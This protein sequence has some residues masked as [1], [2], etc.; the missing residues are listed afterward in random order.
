MFGP[1][2][3]V[4]GGLAGKA[5]ATI[6]GMGDYTVQ[7][8]S[9]LDTAMT[10][11]DSV[12][13]FVKN[14]HSVTIRHREYITDLAVPLTPGAFDLNSYR[15]N[16]GDEKT[17][18]WLSRIARQYQ[19]YKFKGAVFVYKTMS[20]DITAGGALGTVVIA[21]NYN[22]NDNE[23][24]SKMQMEQSEFC[25]STK[26]SQSILHP[27]ECAPGAG[28][29]EFL[30]VRTPGSESGAMQDARL[31]DWG[32]TQVATV[33]LPGTTGNVLGELWVSYDIELTKP[34][35]APELFPGT[36]EISGTSSWTTATQNTNPGFNQSLIFISPGGLAGN[37][38][39]AMHI[40]S[41]V[42][43]VS[44]LTIDRPGIY[45]IMLR[46]TG[47]SITP[48]GVI[49]WS[50][51]AKGYSGT[52]SGLKYISTSSDSI[53]IAVLNVPVEAV[54]ST[55]ALTGY[56][57]AAGISSRRLTASVLQSLY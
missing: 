57:T 3:G 11:A 5:V 35:L 44:F 12:P 32:K 49:T 16:P 20:S 7:S 52:D 23:F 6:T 33:G 54:G 9:L 8:N 29:A 50:P 48:S 22:T 4:L 13:Q 53:L 34:I 14:E 26:P 15:L 25:V 24:T 2:G 28:R 41:T 36:G 17:F 47:S 18:P 38:V 1:V 37:D 27:I 45:Q 46:Y 55:A 42:L 56:L 43:N 39:A 51:N 19:E 31:Y 21:T 40:S 30:Y 10:T